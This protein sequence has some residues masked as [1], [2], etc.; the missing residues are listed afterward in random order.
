MGVADPG[1]YLHHR[2]LRWALSQMPIEPRVILDAGSGTGDHSIYLAQRFPRARVLGVDVD[3][4]RVNRC[5]AAVQRMGLDNVTF[6]VGD[7]TQLT[8]TESFDLVLSIDVLEHIPEQA[9]AVRHLG[10]ALR[11]GGWFFFHVPTV[12]PR[13]VPLDRWLGGFHEWAER[14]HLADERS[15]D[16]FLDVVR[17]AG[18]TIVHHR[19]TF[20][21][22][23]GELATSIF[24]LARAPTRRNRV[25][26]ALL[27]PAC[28][29]LVM[30]DTLEPQ[31]TRY[32]I[33][34]VGCRE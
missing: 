28:R 1:H 24:N 11:K 21:Y 16:E 18:L 29:L 7:L 30:A 2:Y 17:Q 13:P 5:R 6:E 3:A 25:L 33:G 34:V 14:E 15:A 27:A 8:R 31:E 26:Q 12:R 4:E 23:T 32:A 19:K 9:S 10:H 20:G 22:H